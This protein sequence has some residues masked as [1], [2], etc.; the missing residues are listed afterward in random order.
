MQM[1]P[2]VLIVG[3]GIMGASTAFFLAEAGLGDSTVVLE[4][5]TVGNGFSSMSTGIVRC[6]YGHPALVSMA[7]RSR[8]FFEQSCD[9]LGADIGFRPIGY[10][11]GAG[12]VDEDAL[13]R[14][15]ELQ[16]SL[17]AEVDIVPVEEIAAFWPGIESS[18][19]SL[20]AFEAG[21]GYGD[22]YLTTQGMAA[23]ARSRGVDI[24]QRQ[25][26]RR[27]VVSSD[28]GEVQ[29]VQLASGET[30]WADI[31]V[32]AAGPWSV[33]LCDEI[34]VEVPISCHREPKLVLHWP[35]AVDSRPVLAD[36]LRAQYFRPDSRDTVIYGSTQT[37]H[38]DLVDPDRFDSFADDDFVD[39]AITAIDQ[40]VHRDD[41]EI[42][43]SY[44]GCYDIT[45][46]LY[47]IIGRCDV[48]RLILCMGFSGHGFKLSPAVGR[49]VA[50]LIVN[51][52]SSDPHVPTDFF[53]LRR[54]GEGRSIRSLNPYS[55]S[56]Y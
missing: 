17:G 41:I 20:F 15:V 54:F 10:A 3:G 8:R 52:E 14:N 40:L 29:G 34:G 47:P 13:R 56:R 4:R 16:Q 19:I 43:R 42:V 22:G 31:V 21:G 9:L 51:G 50:D 53:A 35:A 48:E 38:V 46:D 33:S 45:P 37:D 5:G 1:T 44:A 39:N 26:V 25:A 28:G 32:V 12:A 18:G 7:L 49:L 30:L 36:R 6:H 11:F 27:L 23:A 2:R 24:R 55:G